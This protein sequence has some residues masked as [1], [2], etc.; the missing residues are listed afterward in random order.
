MCEMRQCQYLHGVTVTAYKYFK[1]QVL[2][3]EELDD[4]L[5]GLRSNGLL[6][7]SYILTGNCSC[8]IC[9]TLREHKFAKF[10]NKLLVLPSL[11]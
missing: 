4:F 2:G 5:T 7:Y 11:H 9:E 8:N 6:K 3:S 10:Y 1:G